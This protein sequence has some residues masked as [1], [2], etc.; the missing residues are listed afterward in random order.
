MMKTTKGQSLVEFALVIPLFLMLVA[1]LLD[2]TRMLFTY[3]ELQEAAHAGARWGAVNVGRTPWGALSYCGNSPTYSPYPTS[4]CS[5]TATGGISSTILGQVNNKLIAIDKTQT[6]VDI[7][8]TAGI[9]SEVGAQ[10]G[11]FRIDPVTVTVSYK[12]KPVL[13]FG[14]FGI[15]LTGSAVAYHE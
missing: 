1:G 7:T 12:F 14:H 4:T 10:D 13:G 15:N 3:N 6:T 11:A 9:T 5:I 8:S 2:G